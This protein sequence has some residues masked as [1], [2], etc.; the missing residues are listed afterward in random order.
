MALLIGLA[1]VLLGIH[2]RGYLRWGCRPAE[3]DQT[4]PPTYRI[5]INHGDRA[6]LL[7]VSGV[8]NSL[9]DRIEAHRRE[10]GDFQSVDQLIEVR[11]IG[12]ATLER[13]RPWVGVGGDEPTAATNPVLA[14]PKTTSAA[15]KKETAGSGPATPSKKTAGLSQPIDINQA[16]LEELQRLPGVGPVMS[17]R[18][19][20]ERRKA[21]FKSVDDLRR[22]KGIGQKTLEK[23]RPFITVRSDAGKIVL[24]D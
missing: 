2:G 7:Q 3:L 15:R 17:Q 12:P 9:A 19:V 10:H 1:T 6:E 16:S 20:E 4:R 24:A 18:I 23:L 13:L 14:K 5:D 22:V 21:P 11:G 8:G